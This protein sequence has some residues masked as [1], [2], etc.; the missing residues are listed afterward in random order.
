MLILKYAVED[1]EF[2]AA[3]MDMRRKMA[4][5]RIADNGGCA[6]NLTANAVEHPAVNAC[7]WRRHPIK[8]VATEKYA[9]VEIGIDFHAAHP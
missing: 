9:F 1:D 2:L 3:F 5:W 8:A 7:H 6:C 4:V